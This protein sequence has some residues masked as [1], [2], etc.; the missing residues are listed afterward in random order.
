MS[1]VLTL[2]VMLFGLVSVPPA[3]AEL[4]AGPDAP[5]A[6]ADGDT[7]TVEWVATTSDAPPVEHLVE[8]V[9]SGAVV[10]TSTTSPAEFPA[11]APGT[12]LARLVA[13]DS[14]SP[15]DSRTSPSSNAVTVEDP[16]GPP[17]TP[18]V[19][20]SATG[21]T[22][23]TSWLST[24]DGSPITGYLVEL[25]RAT[26]G[27]ALVESKTVTTTATTF[28]D[29][30]AGRYRV[31]VVATSAAGDSDD[32]ES[33]QVVVDEPVG[34]PSTPGGVAAAAVD[35]TVTV[36]W[37]AA[38]ANGSPVTGYRITLNGQTR[39]TG[40]GGR[41]VQ[42]TNVAAG[43][44]TA[45]VIA[46]SAA[47]NS[48]A[49]SDSVTVAL[50]RT[51]PS[52]PPRNMSADPSGSSVTIS[53][54]PPT[55]TANNDATGYRIE[56]NTGDVRTTTG[57]GRSVT[58]D[59]LDAGDYSFTARATN[60]EGSG[61]DTDGSFSIR[62]VPSAPANVQVN[63]NGRTVTVS[64][65]A[66]S[67]DGNSPIT[68]YLV[69]LSDGDAVVVA[70]DAEKIAEFDALDLGEYTV[71]VVAR[72]DV[73][74]GAK[75]SSAAVT[76][77]RPFEPFE[78]EEA[79]IRQQYRDFLGR[80]ADAAGLS[81]WQGVT[82]ND[83]SN[84]DQVVESFMKSPEFAPRRSIARLYLAFFDR[85]PDQGGFDYWAGRITTGQATLD[86]ISGSFVGSQEFQDTYGLLTDA[87]FVALV[88]NN[89]LLRSPDAAGYAFWL[90]RMENG[91]TR[92]EL[93]TEFSE[94]PEFVKATRPAV[95]VIVTYR[96]MLNRA[97]DREGFQF[98]VVKVADDPNS[99][100]A[101]IK[102]FYFSE[103][104]GVRVTP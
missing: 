23:E 15:A 5:V 100:L 103:E 20:A 88:Y 70:A 9:R 71:A 75:A 79:F 19:S 67:S 11:L 66:P 86:T 27:G 77:V 8:L 93:M 76:T 61:G 28:V 38:T 1:S 81:F 57:G 40:A 97:P 10:A 39:T 26:G 102:G 91:L 41:S 46:T 89:V 52:G 18:V 64:W 72:N 104:Y 21:Q 3:A 31:R 29:V 33:A 47:G 59:N 48:A 90:S 54:A 7:V 56:L 50:P 84:V 53:W 96:G 35:Q 95:N 24:S 43:S 73:G 14:D 51:A 17:S 82:T 2:L 83:R 63:A 34:P 99:L 22:I 98:W 13:T 12:Y 74:D 94:S 87:Q 4:T 55:V 58:F 6:S 30:A 45:T 68:E 32:G 60:E 16:V 69:T 49:G 42:F 25:R 101:L 37:T 44:H 65:S 80:E 92:G 78:T 36:R 62:L 85:A